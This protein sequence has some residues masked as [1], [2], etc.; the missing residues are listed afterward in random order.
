MAN[1]NLKP[2]KSIDSYGGIILYLNATAVE[3][4]GM[5]GD[6]FTEYVRIGLS[7]PKIAKQTGD[8]VTASTI[9]SWR[10]RLKNGTH[11]D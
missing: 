11:K 6:K 9:K 10:R 4:G 3:H 2:K 1:P 5:T 7:D 8:S